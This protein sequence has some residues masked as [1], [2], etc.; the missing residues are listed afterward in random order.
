MEEIS[1]TYICRQQRRRAI[2][3]AK[4]T[5]DAAALR[6]GCFALSAIR[7][8]RDPSTATAAAC[9]GGLRMPG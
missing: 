6:L 4:R 1:T 9:G 8:N 3:V 5:L 2:N 7:V